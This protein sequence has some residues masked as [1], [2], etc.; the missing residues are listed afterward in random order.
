[1]AR[2]NSGMALGF[3]SPMGYVALSLDRVWVYLHEGVGLPLPLNNT[4]PADEL[5]AR[6]FPYDSMNLVLGYEKT[7]ESLVG[8]PPVDPRVYAPS[9]VV[10]VDHWREAVRR[11]S[12][13]HDFR[14]CALVERSR[15]EVK[16]GSKLSGGTARITSFQPERVGIR[17]ESDG[18]MLVVL[19]EA[20]YPGW[21][22]ELDGRGGLPSFPVNAWM[23]G[24]LVPPGRH[25]VVL[26]YRSRFLA[27]GM[28]LSLL[29]LLAVAGAFRSAHPK[30]R[31]G[32]AGESGTAPH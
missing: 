19:A 28:L 3:S 25:D 17:T 9:C 21:R 27:P 15:A 20:W 18:E 1:V 29:C 31:S 24:V 14:R 12:E 4:F 22:A 13:G 32:G 10:A 16:A 7:T 2:F 26:A 11:M 23:R 6:A 8:R 5:W 30:A